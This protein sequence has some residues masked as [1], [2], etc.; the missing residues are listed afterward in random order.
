MSRYERLFGRKKQEPQT[1]IMPD[2]S[3]VQESAPAVKKKSFGLLPGFVLAFLLVGALVVYLVF[4]DSGETPDVEE[5]SAANMAALN[6]ADTKFKGYLN[7]IN[8]SMD[9]LIAQTSDSLRLI[10]IRTFKDY[11]ENA[12][13]KRYTLKMASV[14]QYDSLSFRTYI[15]TLVSDLKNMAAESSIQLPN[16]PL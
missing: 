3:Q 14:T 8:L 12:I 9:S 4:R 1:P 11:K 13:D 16:C 10:D 15:E 2:N 6:V 7:C 5:P